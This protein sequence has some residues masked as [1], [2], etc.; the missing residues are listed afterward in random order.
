MSF[1]FTTP[2]G[3]FEQ[4]WIIYAMLRDAVQHHLEGGQPSPE[5][6]NLHAIAQALGGSS[7]V[8]SATALHDEL[9]RAKRALCHLPADQLAISMRTRSLLSLQWPPPDRRATSLV[10]E[11][12]AGVPFLGQASAKTLD[13]VFGHLIDG[14]LQITKECG[15]D[16]KMQVLD[17]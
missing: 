9:Q 1:A 13:E 8:V 10:K 3:A 11:E 15:P 12:G 14:L 4:R 17:M 5:F 16:D 7:V 2:K 6:A